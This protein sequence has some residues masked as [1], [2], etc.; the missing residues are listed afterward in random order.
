M[1]PTS[2]VPW[3]GTLY[4]SRFIPRVTPTAT[5]RVTTGA[6]ATTGGGAGAE[7]AGTVAAAIWG[8]AS[9]NCDRSVT[10]TRWVVSTAAAPAARS[11]SEWPPGRG[12]GGGVWV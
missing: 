11:T 4:S 1:S 12:A 10:A 9:S 3:R 8:A 2:T 7:G 5:V 6:A